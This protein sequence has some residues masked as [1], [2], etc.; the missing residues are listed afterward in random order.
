MALNGGF[1]VIRSYREDPFVAT[2]RA[3][4]SWVKA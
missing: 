3:D 2:R 1:A 4:A